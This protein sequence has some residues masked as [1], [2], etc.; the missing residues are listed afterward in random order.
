MKKIKITTFA[1]LVVMTVAVLTACSSKD[2]AMDKNTNPSPSKSTSGTNQGTM[3]ESGESSTGN[4]GTNE[5]GTG[6]RSTQGNRDGADEESSTGV[7]GGMID[8]VENGVDDM[9]SGRDTSTGS[10]ENK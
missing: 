1:I 2:P 9:M 10:N 3:N 4:A 5:S 6:S 8:D 7:I